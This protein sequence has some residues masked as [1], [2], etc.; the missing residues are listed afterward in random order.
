[1]QVTRMAN[2]VWEPEVGSDA[3]RAGGRGR[4]SGRVRAALLAVAALALAA[5]GD[6]GRRIAPPPFDGG[7][8]DGATTD[9][10]DVDL[11]AADGGD[12]DGG[13][14]DGARCVDADGDGYGEGCA[15]GPDCA[16]DDATRNPAAA[17]LC[18]GDDDDCDGEVD[19]GVEAPRCELSA[20]VCAGATARCAGAGGFVMCAADEYGASY[21]LVESRCDGLDNDCDGITDEGCECRPGATQRCGTDEGACVAGTQTCGADGRWGACEGEVTPAAETCNGLDDDCD[22]VADEPTDLVPVDCALQQGVCAGARAVCAGVAGHLACVG[23]GSYGPRYQEVETACDRLDNDCDG[24]VD[25]GCACVDGDTQ[26]CGSDVGVCRAGVQTCVRGVFGACEGAVTGGDETCNGLD[27]DCDGMTDE[28]LVGPLCAL[29]VGVCAG[30]RQRCGGAAGF[31]AC[32]GTAS[33]GPSY[34]AIETRC[35]GLDNDCDGTVDEGCACVVG[36]TQACGTNVGACRAGTQTCGPT[37]FGECA[38]AVGPSPEVC[39]GVD[40]DCNGVADEG[41]TAP[42]CALTAGVCAGARQTCGGAAGFLACTPASYGP[43]YAAVEDG[44]TNEALCDG[45]DNDCD[46]AVDEG[47]T[48]RAVVAGPQ[49]EY[50]P[51]VFGHHL[52]FLRGVGSAATVWFRDLRTGAERALG[53]TMSERVRVDV[54]GNWVVYQRGFDANSA[55]AIVAHDLATGTERTIV[56]NNG[57]FPKIWRNAVGWTDVRSGNADVWLHLLDTGTSFQVTSS[58]SDEFLTDVGARGTLYVQRIGTADSLLL[59]AFGATVDTTLRTVTGGRSIVEALM[60]FEGVAWTEAPV[61]ATGQWTDDYESYGLLLS[62][63]ATVHP[64]A[65][66]RNAQLVTSIDG[67]IVLLSDYRGGQLDVVAAGIGAGTVNVTSG[68]PTQFEGTIHGGTVI[69]ADDRA[70]NFDLYGTTLAGLSAPMPGFIVINEV[71]ADPPAGADVNGDGTADTSQDEFVEIVNATTGAIDLSGVI[72]RDAVGTRHVFAPGTILA[73]GSSI[74]VFGGGGTPVGLWGGATAVR[75]S[76][77]MLGLNNTGETLTVLA[78]DG[79]TV[80]DATTWGAE[81]NQDASLVRQPEY[82]GAFTRHDL[83]AGAVGRWSPGTLVTGWGM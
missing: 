67:M 49:D 28:G 62:A 56:A 8:V 37:G 32:S 45:L 40:D 20:G 2:G 46:G 33:Y 81:G 70:G 23:T 47:C 16:D 31:L 57:R 39:N 80:L 18:N 42:A 68:P 11:G 69:W 4:A 54:H 38:G 65:S 63:P 14:V 51:A 29:R 83:I 24:V 55:G 79:T 72:V 41:L 43:R 75:A 34:Q 71:L 6:G 61:G 13:E 35:D 30:S 26:P 77:G 19:E 3:Q 21:E 17:E 76:T 59:R 48:A 36:T 66:G 52:V 12:A 78:A 73:S 9:A 25:E 53:P 10:G 5:C 60:D 58:A 50:A 22:G 74:V 27:D 64:L 7:P 1:M 82:T 44:A 15:R